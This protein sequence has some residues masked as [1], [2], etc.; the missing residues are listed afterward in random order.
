MI[1]TATNTVTTTVTVGGVP[2]WAAITPDGKHV[3]VTQDYTTVT[4]GTVSVIDTATNTVTTTV[5]VGTEPNAVNGVAVTPDGQHVY[6][7][8][9]LNVSVI[10]TA[11][12]TVVG[13]PILVGSPNQVAVTPDGKH[14]YVTNFGSN[15]VIDTA[16]NTVTATVTVGTS[17]SGVGIMPPP[18]PTLQVS[19]P[20][21]IAA[22]GIQGQIFSPASFNYQLSSSSGSVPYSISRIPSWLNASF[23][24]GTVPPPVTVKFSVNA[25]G[26]G[27]GTYSATIAFTNTSSGQGNTTR[28][29]T[30]TP[31]TKDDCKYG[32]WQNFTCSPGPFKNQ[33]QCVRY[34]AKHK[35]EHED[36]HNE[37]HKEKH[38]R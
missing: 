37:E 38:A 23:T 13:T 19:P 31:G 12:N 28:A 5:T 9:G 10:D 7:T 18:P 21:D 26:F 36:E 15:P 2:F 27:P 3:Y 16:T 25:C 14:A 1:D 35:E 33:G 32:G 24:S 11:T 20:N 17:P 22:S 6:V 8:N 29:A 4:P 34:F 30:L